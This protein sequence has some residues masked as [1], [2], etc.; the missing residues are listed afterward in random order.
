MEE[1]VFLSSTDANR[2]R[3]IRRLARLLDEA[4]QIPG[5]SIRLGMDGIVG[6]LPG[7]GDAAT[8]LL[9]LYIVREAAKLGVPRA[10][11]MRMLVN[12]G[13]D[14][15]AGTIP[16][17]GDLVDVAWKCNKMNVELVDAHLRSHRPHAALPQPK[18]LFPWRRS[19]E[20]HGLG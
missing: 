13:I 15:A 14:L 1:Q 5:T 6:L 3:R 10:T 20:S 18:G 17:V 8:A 2:L 16:V 12:I 11:L 7:V 4:I 19:R 9:S